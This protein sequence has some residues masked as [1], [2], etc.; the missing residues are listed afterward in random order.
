MAVLNYA[1]PQVRLA[2][3]HK[4]LQLILELA[5]QRELLARAE[6]LGFTSAENAAI[7]EAFRAKE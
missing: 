2:Q 1:P 7:I 5:A 6:E 4:D 3:H